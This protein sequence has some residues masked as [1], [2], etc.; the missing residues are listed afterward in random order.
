MTFIPSFL[1]AIIAVTASSPGLLIFI[2]DIPY[3]ILANNT[4]L[5]ERLL[6]EDNSTEPLIQMSLSGINLFN[7]LIAI[8]LVEQYIPTKLIIK[9]DFNG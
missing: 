1:I 5:I 6:S 3:A 7:F 2:R 8:T 9:R 4:D